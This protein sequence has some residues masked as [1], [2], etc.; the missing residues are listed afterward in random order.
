MSQLKIK[1]YIINESVYNILL[2]VKDELINNKL[3]IVENKG[4]YVRV[5]C[6]FH[7]DGKENKPSCSVSDNDSLEKGWFHCFT[8][9]E[10]GNFIKFI[11]VCKGITYWS[12]EQ[13]L[14]KNFGIQIDEKFNIDRCQRIFPKKYD[15]EEIIDDSVLKKFEDFHPYMEKRKLSKDI[16]KKFEIKYDPKEQSLIFPVRDFYG[17][18]I[19]LSK[20]SVN[21]KQFI[22][23]KFKN[24]PVY[25]LGEI[26]INKPVC[27]CE[28]QINALYLWS[29]GYQAIALFGTGSK[30]QYE[31]LNKSGIKYYKLCFDGDIAGKEGVK[32][33]KQSIKSNCFI[34]EILVPENKDINDL[35]EQDVRRL[36]K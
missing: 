5:T 21:Y 1:N 14:I 29:L 22:L 3:N 30:Y 12:A 27:V 34:D 36:L 26:D 24:K 11:S 33:F 16:C 7:K 17:R 6:P 10:K 4:D 15:D 18:L 9:G 28:S 19:G 31:Q 20:R 8:C 35:E 13:W 2:K 25:L 23:P 32:K